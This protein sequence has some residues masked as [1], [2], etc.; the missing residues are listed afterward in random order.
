MWGRWRW[1]VAVVRRRPFLQKAGSKNSVWWLGELSGALPGESSLFLK[2]SGTATIMAQ[3]GYPDH[4]KYNVEATPYDS[5]IGGLPKWFRN[6]NPGSTLPYTC[7]ACGAP[8]FLVAQIYAPVDYARSLAIFGCNRQQCSKLSSTWRVV[9]T[10]DNG[11]SNP[12]KVAAAA[13]AGGGGVTDDVTG[14]VAAEAAAAV[15]SSSSS[16]LASMPT[17]GSTETKTTGTTSD[18]SF[19]GGDDGGGWGDS[20]G[21]GDDS[22]FATGFA[23]EA[24][25]FGGESS[26]STAT[27]A[28]TTPDLEA[29]LQSRD[30]SLKNQKK[31]KG[32]NQK[33]KDTPKPAEIPA[34]PAAAT[35]VPP[36]PTSTPA[37][38]NASTTTTTTTTAAAAAAVFPEMFLYVEVEPEQGS[39]KV[40]KDSVERAVQRHMKKHCKTTPT[41]GSGTAGDGY[42]QTPPKEKALQHYQ[43]RIVRAP[44]QCLRYAY[45]T[46]P[47]WP[48]PM[49][50]MQ[51]HV[52]QVPSK[53]NPLVAVIGP[54]M[55]WRVQLMC[56]FFV[57]ISFF[58]ITRLCVW[59]QKNI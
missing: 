9:R 52:S 42:I 59:G 22:G 20:G 39:Q 31:S 17:T 55:R 50:D 43:Q 53:L 25:G 32:S 58:Y 44:K 23:T 41:S 35:T 13:A 7:T 29:L 48:S 8:L 40:A 49:D 24:G 16:S 30:Q 45:N 15:T 37:P 36:A 5:K 12:W 10:Q 38:T 26:V 34:A 54:P 11:D 21:W 1:F 2:I 57:P 47:L 27:S 56:F 51:Q 6:E 19:G 4:G 14:V 46:V 18:L 33:K 28:T 3:L